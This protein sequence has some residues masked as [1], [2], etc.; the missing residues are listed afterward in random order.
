[1]INNSVVENTLHN[2]KVFLTGH[3]GFKGSWLTQWLLNLECDVT[4]Y[5]LEADK[6]SLFSNLNFE[7]QT[8]LNQVND[9]RDSSDLLNSM[10][11]AEPELVIHLAAQ[12]LVR[13]S[14]DYSELTWSTNVLGTVNLLE[15]VRRCPSVRAV[16]IITTDKCY[17]NQEWAWGY[18]ETDT[19]GGYDPYSASKAAAELVVS[20]YRKSFFDD[21]NVLVASARAGNVIGGGDWSDDR[22]I[23][24]A[25]RSV[26]DKKPL[27]IRNPK[28]TRPWQH[29]LDCLHGYLLLSS[30]LLEGNRNFARAFNFGPSSDSNLAV[31]EVLDRLQKYWPEL[32]WELA[33]D[34][35][36]VNLHEANFLYLD[37]SLS[38]NMLNWKPHWDVEIALEKTADWYRAVIDNPQRA[39]EITKLQLNEFINL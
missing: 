11:R 5:A 22:L 4:G 24:D 6:N 1:M 9:V 35:T 37:S 18:R 29:V 14:Y 36:S 32:K 15:A 12:S 31:K 2:R 7:S 39:S 27:V 3:T 26:M 34:S 21:R 16:V 25:A 30:Q 10:M 20:S 17:D 8:S 23:P 33:P 28:A 13:K 19:L 38:K